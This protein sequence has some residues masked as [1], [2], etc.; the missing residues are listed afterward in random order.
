MSLNLNAGKEKQYHQ[1]RRGWGHPKAFAPVMWNDS[2]TSTFLLPYQIHRALPALSPTNKFEDSRVCCEIRGENG[3]KLWLYCPCSVAGL[4]ALLTLRLV[5]ASPWL[6]DAWRQA[7][8]GTQGEWVQRPR[9]RSR[10]IQPLFPVLGEW[11][12]SLLYRF[13]PSE[14]QTLWK[15]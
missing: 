6:F 5:A 7:A 4:L 8:E 12:Q 15:R 14:N 11:F 2:Y 13:E 1:N 9:A 10:T 3:Q